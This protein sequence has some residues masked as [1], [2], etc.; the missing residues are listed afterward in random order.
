M[1]LH[2]IA[3][4][5]SDR[6]F[7]KVVTCRDQS[8]VTT[9]ASVSFLRSD[10]GPQ[11]PREIGLHEDIANLGYR[12]VRQEDAFSFGPPGKDRRAGSDVFDA[13]FINRKPVGQ[14]DRKSTRL[15]SSHV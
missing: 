10:N 9:A 11:S 2:V 14:L 1:R 4:A 8:G 3:D 6:A 5:F 12:A 13:Q 7:V 15:N